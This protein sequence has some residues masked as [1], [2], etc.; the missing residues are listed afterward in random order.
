MIQFVAEHGVF[1]R[2]QRLEDGGIRIKAAGVQD[3]VLAK[4]LR[5]GIR[6]KASLGRRG[7]WVPVGLQAM[8]MSTSTHLGAVEGCDLALQVLVNVLRSA[9]E[10]H[11]GQATSM[12]VQRTLGGCNHPGVVWRAR[13]MTQGCDGR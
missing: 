6:K 3:G 1:R 13:E 11:R 12:R 9:D 2:Q 5:G 8:E 7:G 4:R 10:A